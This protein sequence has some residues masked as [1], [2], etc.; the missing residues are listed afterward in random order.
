M[1]LTGREIVTS[2]S[3][4]GSLQTTTAQ[5]VW[6]TETT[7]RAEASNWLTSQSVALGD[8][9]PD[10]TGLFLDSL[11]YSPEADGTYTITGNYS[12]S[13]LFVLEQ[14]NK[15]NRDSAPYVRVNF[16]TYDYTIDVPYALRVTLNVP[17]NPAK[18]IWTAQSQ[19]ISKSD[20][21]LSVEVRPNKLT[22]GDVAAIAKETQRVHRF[23][24]DGGANDWLFMGGNIRNASNTQDLVTYTW[25]RDAGDFEW[26]AKD[27]PV[28][29]TNQNTY[30]PMKSGGASTVWFPYVA[31]QP[32]ARWIMRQNQIDPSLQPLFT[33]MFPYSLNALGYKNLPGLSD[34]MGL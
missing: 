9:H 31:R 21:I 15:Q 1:P 28:L 24:A 23:A 6:K 10:L 30:D 34:I 8:A 7:S 18:F 13:G 29:S 32:H 4:T 16:S 19:K 11:T 22:L 27:A 3:Y 26:V 12:T 17:G 5:R 2:R 33:T 25:Q 14:V 20:V